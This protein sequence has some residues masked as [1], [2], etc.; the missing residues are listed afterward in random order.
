GYSR[1]LT[2]SRRPFTTGD[3]FICVIA[4]TDAQWGRLFGVIGHEALAED[5][6]YASISSRLANVDSLYEIIEG[7]LKTRGTDEWVALF[8]AAD[9]PVAPVQTLSRL[10]QDP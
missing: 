9:V 3:G 2:P 7:A 6:R 1:V 4:N 10:Q 8:E 5:E